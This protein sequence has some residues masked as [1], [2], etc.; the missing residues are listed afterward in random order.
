MSSGSEIRQKE[1]DE[2]QANDYTMDDELYFD[3]CYSVHD[4]VEA[5][6]KLLVDNFG[7]AMDRTRIKEIISEA[8]HQSA[9]RYNNEYDGVDA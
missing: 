9:K 3:D 2:L 8:C 7:I 6:C 5:S 1:F 4:V